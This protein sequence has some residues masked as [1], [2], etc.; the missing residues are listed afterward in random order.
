MNKIEF[1]Y[2]DDKYCVQ[3]NNDDKMKDIISKL[4]SKMGKEKKNMVFLYNGVMINEE[5]SFSHCANRLDRS[6]N[7]M[8]VVIIEG[9]NLNDDSI[10]LKKSNYVICPQCKENAFLSLND[11]RLSVTGCKS[12]HKSEDLEL[13]EFDKTQFV[14]QSKI[15]CDKC[16]ISK[17]DNIFFACI[18]CQQILCSRCCEEHDESHKDY[19]KDFEEI[20]FYCNLHCNEYS[21]YCTD[22]KKE[23]CPLCKDEHKEHKLI[24]YDIIMQDYNNLKNKELKDTREKIFQLKT[25]I[26]GMIYQLNQLNK[27]LDAYFEIFYNIISNYDIKKRNYY[28]IQN[29]NNTKKF[30][31]NFLLNITEIIKNNN[32]K[33]QFTNIISLQSKIDFIR[34][35]KNKQIEERVG[36]NETIIDNNNSG[37]DNRGVDNPLDDKYENFNINKMEELQSFD[38]KN[39]IIKLLILNDGRILTSQYY[40]DENGENFYKLCVY[41]IKNGFICDINIDFDSIWNFYQMDDGKVIIR[42]LLQIQ[43]IKIQKNNIIIE[44]TFDKKP[45]KLKKLLKDKFLIKVETNKLNTQINENN[46]RKP[47]YKSEDEIYTYD[48]GKLIFYKNIDKIEKDEEVRNICQVSENEYVFYANQKGTIYGTNDYLIFYD[49]KN[50]EI[51]K[52]LKVGKGENDYDMILLNKGNLIISGKDSI[53]LIDVKNRQ[54]IKELDY[55]VYIDTITCLNDNIFLFEYKGN[56]YQYEL[57]DLKTIKLK[58]EKKM[59]TI[60]ISKY[61]IIPFLFFLLLI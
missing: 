18:K 51:I 43:I 35:K 39:E 6:R 4:L 47:R 38:I 2:N 24:I 33:S 50:E 41:S 28:I 20:H 49:M 11:F 32:L 52:K 19:I 42:K 36:Q 30:N 44:W 13:K 7:F 29:I 22:C 9:Q 14:D 16:H 46:L 26:N 37:N 34:L 25:I 23:L 1:T 59:K 10:N 3:C 5:L 40:Y 57:E 60:F 61:L 21:F 8:N 48:K 56:L 31:D 55:N 17:N 45:F 53:I 12:E 15:F 27:S 54:T 58:E